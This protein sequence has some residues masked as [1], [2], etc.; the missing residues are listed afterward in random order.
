[1]NK[2]KIKC[3]CGHNKSKHR[4][5][6]YDWRGKGACVVWRCGCKRFQ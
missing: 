2:E 6:K 4:S 3:N 5:S 1:M